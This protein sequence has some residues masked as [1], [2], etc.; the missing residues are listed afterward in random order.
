MEDEIQEGPTLTELP[1]S[2]NAKDNGKGLTNDER[3]ARGMKPVGRPR[4]SGTGRAP[5]Q[6]RGKRNLTAQLQTYLTLANYMFLLPAVPDEVRQDMLD[7]IEIA[8]LAKA[9][10][11][12]AQSNKRIYKLLDD[13][14]SGGQSGVITL[15]VILGAMVGRRL[16]RHGVLPNSMDDQLGAMIAIVH[17]PNAAIQM[18]PPTE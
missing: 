16:S 7:D 5:S 18:P 12:A 4:G 3:I 1:P 13:A 6:P 11:D 15:V 10:N 17:D 2:D 14:L 8:A 9:I